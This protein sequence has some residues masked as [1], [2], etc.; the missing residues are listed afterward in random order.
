MADYATPAV[1][2]L[3]MNNQGREDEYLTS[4]P[5]ITFFK[6]TYINPEIFIKDEMVFKDIPMKWDDTTFIKIPKD[7]HLLGN[8][9]VTV[10]IPYFQILEK[11]TST[12]TTTT[13]NANINEMIFDNY[14]TYLVYINNKYYTDVKIMSS[15]G[16]WSKLYEEY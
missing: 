6:K 8:I 12:T 5:N 3:Y 7:I 1:M 16:C 10:N 14:L 2:Q 9:W 4:N 11:T 13:N 15:N